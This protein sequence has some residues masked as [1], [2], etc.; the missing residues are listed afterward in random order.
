MITVVGT[1]VFAVIMQRIMRAIN[2]TIKGIEF[3]GE[4]IDKHNSSGV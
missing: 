2:T 4:T 1:S 3:H